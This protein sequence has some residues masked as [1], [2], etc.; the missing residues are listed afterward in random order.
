MQSSYN[1]V[2]KGQVLEGD[3]KVINTEYIPPKH[4]SKKTEIT[5]DPEIYI[6]SYENIA[7]NILEDARQKSENIRNEKKLVT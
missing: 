7:K 6:G 2:K 4:I 1:L 5:C 3:S